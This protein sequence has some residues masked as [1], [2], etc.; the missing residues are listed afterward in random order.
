MKLLIEAAKELL[1]H[2]VYTALVVYGVYLLAKNMTAVS[3][4]LT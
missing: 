2:S 1:I 3:A 4:V